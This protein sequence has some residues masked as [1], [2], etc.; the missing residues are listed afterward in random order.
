MIMLSELSIIIAYL[1]DYRIGFL[2]SLLFFTGVCIKNKKEKVKEKLVILLILSSPFFSISILGD[3]LH[4]VFSWPIIFLTLLSIIMI[5][6]KQTLDNIKSKKK[7]WAIIIL[8]FIFIMIRNLINSNFT[9]GLTDYIQLL[10]MFFPILLVYTNKQMFNFSDDFKYEFKIN[11]YIISVCVAMALAVFVQYIYHV[12]FNMIIGEV[13]IYSGRIIYDLF[14]KGYSVLSIFLGT[15]LVMCF[16]ELYR[17][18][19][20]L[21]L[22]DII[23]I[24]TSIGINSSRAGLISGLIVCGV[25]FL[26]GINKRENL[27]I[28]IIIIVCGVLFIVFGLKMFT[29]NRGLNNLFA[30][31]GRSQN[32]SEAIKTITNNPT[33][34]FVGIGLVTEGYI[35]MLPHNF[36]LQYWL[37]TGLL[38]LIII[39]FLLY[40]LLHYLKGSD[41]FYIILS[42][43]IG[44]LFI[45]DFH[46]NIFFTVFAIAGIIQSNIVRK[47]DNVLRRKI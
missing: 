4:H 30:D 27:L 38:A 15:G 42:I 6:N 7:I 47:K 13:S 2:A 34:F 46:A 16:I 25:L 5:F 43:V 8:L 40:R 10:L 32:Y 28:N 22:I 14:F 17:R 12:K 36:I 23:I 45:T 1:F 18:K 33:N 29:T 35:Y 37:T 31:N 3:R 11:K 19:S 41:Y 20:F 21:N 44:C 9:S 39:L 26:K 24:V